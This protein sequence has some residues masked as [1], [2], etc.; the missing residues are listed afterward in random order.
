[1]HCYVC[2]NIEYCCASTLDTSTF[3]SVSWESSESCPGMN[4]HLAAT[5]S[6]TR[7]SCLP[8][9]TKII[10]PNSRCWWIWCPLHPNVLWVEMPNS[11]Y[12]SSPHLMPPTP[13]YKACSRLMASAWGSSACQLR[14]MSTGTSRTPQKSKLRNPDCQVAK[15][16]TQENNPDV[17]SCIA[18][19]LP[20]WN[21][22]IQPNS[23]AVLTK[24]TS[25]MGNEHAL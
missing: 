10:S 22:F 20:I 12:P 13:S 4:Q 19:C 11:C 14:A 3:L 23:W 8:S 17:F 16:Q 24:W 2:I 1:M 15:T 18:N 5:S 25:F 21:P 7:D 6:H 9:L